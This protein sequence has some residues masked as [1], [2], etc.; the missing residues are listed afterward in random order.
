MIPNDHLTYRD[1]SVKS[2][3][4]QSIQDANLLKIRVLY[5]Y[6]MHV[7]FVNRVING[8]LRIGSA[9]AP[10]RATVGSVGLNRWQNTGAPGFVAPSGSFEAQCLNLWQTGAVDEWRRHIPIVAQA[11]V[12]MHTPAIQAEN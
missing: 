1:A 8:L 4:N 6:E 9:V 10:G 11:I 7:P 5:C 12:R 3:S 2:N